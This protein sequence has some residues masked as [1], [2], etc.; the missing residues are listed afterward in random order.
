MSRQHDV[1]GEACRILVRECRNH[2]W[3]AVN[4]L[5]QPWPT[6]WSP[7]STVHDHRIIQDAHDIL[8]AAWRYETFGWQLELFS[9]VREVRMCDWLW[10]LEKEIISWH[11]QPALIASVMTVLSH[12]NTNLGYEAQ[13]RLSVLLRERFWKVPWITPRF[14]TK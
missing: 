13:D 11:Q 2:L 5:E 3:R 12:A 4:L 8:A 1:Y 7:E 10:W 6:R 14:G 9:P